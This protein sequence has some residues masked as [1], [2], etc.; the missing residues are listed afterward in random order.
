MQP[1][2]GDK[3]YGNAIPLAGLTVALAIHFRFNIQSD[4]QTICREIATDE[5]LPRSCLR[6][7]CNM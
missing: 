1:A 2:V 7:D 3:L 5:T 6:L 4:M